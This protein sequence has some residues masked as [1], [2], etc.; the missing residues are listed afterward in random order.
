M[1]KVILHDIF[2][3]NFSVSQTFGV[4][5]ATYKWIKDYKGNPIKGHNGIDWTY[6]GVNGIKLI[7]PFP[8]G[9]D[10]V[11]SRVGYDSGGYGWFLRMWDKTQKFVILFAH[12]QEIVVPEWGKLQFQ[13]LVAYGNNTGW[14]T[15]PHL[16]CAGYFVNDKGEKLNRD[17]GF[18]GYINLLDKNLVEWKILN[19]SSP[20]TVTPAEEN[21]ALAVCLTDRKMWWDRFEVEKKAHILTKS[22]TTKEI[23]QLKET[24]KQKDIES[25]KM[26]ALLKKLNESSKLCLT[27]NAAQVETIKQLGIEIKQIRI[28]AQ[29]DLEKQAQDNAIKIKNVR[30]TT[31]D[32]TRALLKPYVYYRQSGANLI[33]LGLI[34]ALGFSIK[35]DIDPLENGGDKKN[36]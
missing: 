11:V 31:T 22:T 4:N 6:K 23:N 9:N 20:A 25:A 2:I 7:N 29:Q 36:G 33:R 35:P 12:N 8:K 34:K 30:Q 21:S 19:P 18:D 15:G 32:Q 14:S 28:K 3:G 1:S 17:N 26:D 13:Q 24:I 5:Y 16:H 10:V 27:T